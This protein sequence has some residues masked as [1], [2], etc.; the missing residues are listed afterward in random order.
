MCKKTNYHGTSNTQIDKCMRALIKYFK[1]SYWTVA[2]CCG[3]GKY[4]I[5]IIAKYRIYKNKRGLEKEWQYYEVLSD[6]ELPRKRR[7][8]KKDK[9]G[10]YYI[11]EVSK[12]N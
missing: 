10:Y 9:Q 6:T 12:P 7:F 11:P 8:Y 5:T 4:P 1:Q 2:S 3:H